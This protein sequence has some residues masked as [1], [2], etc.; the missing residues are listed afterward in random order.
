MALLL[1]PIEM[2]KYIDQKECAEKVEKALFK[3]LESGVKTRDIN[4]S[5]SCTEFTKAIIENL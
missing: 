4:G 5:A 3:T 1:S 2:L